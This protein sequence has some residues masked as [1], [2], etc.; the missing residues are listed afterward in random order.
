MSSTTDFTRHVLASYTLFEKNL[1]GEARG[2]VH[3]LRQGAI[4][5]F[6]KLGIPTLRDEA[7]RF[8]NLRPLTEQTWRPLSA[9]ESPGITSEWIEAVCWHSDEADQ[10]VFVNGHFLEEHSRVGPLPDGVVVGNLAAAVRSHPELIERS[11]ANYDETDT[12]VFTAL[13]TAFLQDGA[14]IFLP[15]GVALERPIHVLYVSA[16]T[17]DPSVSH[18]RTLV[19][20][21]R[22]A[23]A[24]V[25]EE[26]VG[27]EGG[28]PY[29][30]NPVSEIHA[31]DGAE[32]R[33]IRL[34]NDRRDAVHIGSLQGSLA[35]N[36]HVTSLTF[37]FGC[38]LLR[39][40]SG[41]ILDGEGG[42]C[43]VDGLYI[44]GG[45]DLVDNHTLLD[46]SVPDCTS[47]E[48]FKGILDDRS[49]AVFAGRIIVRQDAQRTDSK[50]SNR[51]LL[52]SDQ[53]VAD[54]MPQLEIFADDVKCTHGATVGEL[55]QTQIYYL[56]ARGIGL[57]EARAML[58]FAFAE[59]IIERV[60][61]DS[62]CL[63][64]NRLVVARLDRSSAAHDALADYALA[65]E[66]SHERGTTDA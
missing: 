38:R 34:Q 1:N 43:T 3:R 62:L 66:M 40:T 52:L 31:A 9:A 8:T 22:N 42:H 64:L 32:L 27:V 51:N 29:F 4:E 14:I 41:I 2:P 19:V 23:R 21:E 57:D 48:L 16:P 10:L 24:T 65:D 44:A 39:N 36:S 35:A 5:R 60:G 12:D 28:A 15:E 47:H 37:S 55:D 17:S 13:N 61:I 7:W 45:T 11:L 25:I 54:A 26:Y 6:E 46:H 20:A 50:Q 59:E 30:S 58:T 53:A 33:H 63:H 56:R 18:P 49:R